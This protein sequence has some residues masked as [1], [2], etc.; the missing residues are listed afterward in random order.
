MDNIGALRIISILT[1]DF[2]K[3][4][5]KHFEF[6]TLIDV[7]TLCSGECCTLIGI[8]A[9][10]SGEWRTLIGIYSQHSGE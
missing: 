3:L 10:H 6:C 9:L 1:D 8:Y 4:L 2:I 5:N 7:N